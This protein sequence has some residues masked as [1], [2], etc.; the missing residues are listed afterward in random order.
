[1]TTTV[2]RTQ[3]RR[4][5]VLA[6]WLAASLFAGGMAATGLTAG[7]ETTVS[8]S[9]AG[10]GSPGGI[11]LVRDAY[12]TLNI[13][14]QAT[15]Y[16][17][18]TGGLFSGSSVG[19]SGSAA[20]IAQDPNNGSHNL[21]C[22]GSD[23]PWSEVSVQDPDGTTIYSATSPVQAGSFG[24]GSTY[25]GSPWST[26]L[27]LDGKPSGVYTVTTTIHHKVRS[28]HQSGIVGIA[29]YLLP[30]VEGVPTAA[31]L[32]N[33]A[34]GT[35]TPH[36]PTPND[37]AKF[38][39]TPGPVVETMKF[40]YR[41]WQVQKFNDI[42]GKGTVRFNITPAEFQYTVSGTSSPILDGSSSMTFYNS[43]DSL[44]GAAP[45][46]DCT[47]DPLSCLPVLAAQCT[48]GD[49]GCN[50]RLIVVQ[51][52]SGADQL[53]GIFD[54]DSG[55]FAA[56]AKVGGK[57]RILSSAGTDI[58][59][60]VHDTIDDLDEAAAAQG[61][62]LIGLLSRR[63]QVTL[64]GQVYDISLLQ[65]LEIRDAMPGEVFEE[66]LIDT[67]KLP[68]S[69]ALSA[70]VVEHH[71]SYAG[72]IFNCAA[73]SISNPKKVTS[74]V[75]PSLPASF[76]ILTGALT[77]LAL[78]MAP[79][80]AEVQAITGTGVAVGG[81]PF[82]SYRFDYPDGRGSHMAGHA[83]FPVVGTGPNVD[84][85]GSGLV[86]P[87]VTPDIVV[88]DSGPMNFL[89][90]VNFEIDL[91]CFGGHYFIGTGLAAYGDYP[92][93]VNG[94]PLIWDLNNPTINDL[95]AQL[96]TFIG[97]SVSQAT[98]LLGDPTVG[99][100]LTAALGLAGG[101]DSPV[102]LDEIT[103]L[104]GGEGDFIGL[105]LQVAEDGPDSV[106]GL[107]ETLA[108]LGIAVPEVPGVDPGLLDGV[109]TTVT[110]LLGL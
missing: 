15:S 105:L 46:G 56:L 34:L 69:L 110:G 27:S 85:G 17:R 76:P 77:T 25:R 57:T 35:T 45:G 2:P 53:T 51:H 74:Q 87:G 64:G 24:S 47:T 5:R 8:P 83:T 80:P 67:S 29:A 33:F 90:Y 101:A 81:G 106:D 92:V 84:V 14:T 58:D 65:G 10:A 36:N 32:V 43:P 109:V 30:C 63:T 70:G 18:L 21:R 1:M 4:R 49:A 26:E 41:P 20:Y 96:E 42:F 66:G 98:A 107:L 23:S 28:A 108:D 19:S 75:V 13:G 71:T 16:Q 11:A 12:A 78:G 39:Y 52:Q 6:A 91:L 9:E 72:S 93:D 104:L 100:V 59:G 61:V 22:T 89:G 38:R 31:G 60:L 99:A 86:V 54:L 44:L 95:N 73:P 103:A 7:A 94:I 68:A 37:P 97:D 55:A 62:D 82:T 88:P 40:E 102:S 3:P 79:L 50:P 48:P